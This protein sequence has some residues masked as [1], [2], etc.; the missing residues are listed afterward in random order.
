MAFYIDI[1]AVVSGT[2]MEKEKIT[3]RYQYQNSFLSSGETDDRIIIQAQGGTY[4]KWLTAGS[5]L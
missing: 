2:I 3:A 5:T 1:D 4:S